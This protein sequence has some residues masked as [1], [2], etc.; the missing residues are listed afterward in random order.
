[1]KNSL[2]LKSCSNASLC[3]YTHLTEFAPAHHSGVL[4]IVAPIYVRQTHR[5]DVVI[6]HDLE[7]RPKR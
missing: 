5:S 7:G 2:W 6:E 3:L 4:T 1:M